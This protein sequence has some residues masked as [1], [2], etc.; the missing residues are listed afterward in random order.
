[1][2]WTE[3]C[4][5]IFIETLNPNVTVCGHMAFAEVIKVKQCHKSVLP[6][7]Y[8]WC[9]YKKKKRHQRFLSLA[10]CIHRGKAIR[11]QREKANTASQAE[12]PREKPNLLTP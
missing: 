10:L 7:Q 5:P 8:D 4:P 12:R 9:L 11:V 3:L 6:I 1:M 2:L